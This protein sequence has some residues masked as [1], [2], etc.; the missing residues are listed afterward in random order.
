VA[1]V[2]RGDWTEESWSLTGDPDA[3]RAAFADFA[4]RVRGWLDRVEQQGLWGLFLH[5]VAA[6]W[7]GG[8]AVIIGDAAH[9]TLPFLA[10]GANLALEDAWVLAAALA[11][12]DT[13]E[14]AFAAFQAARAARVV[15][16]VGAAWSN[17]RNYHLT[18]ARRVVSHAGLRVLGA[19]APGAML[20][21]FDWLYGMDVTGG[22]GG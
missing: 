4:P 5:P 20:G 1:V 17:A 3:L 18:G 13:P 12:H 19:V 11:G 22:Q 21:R 2:E 7:H 14:A 16:A 6:R 10:Q 9:P 15:R 8:G